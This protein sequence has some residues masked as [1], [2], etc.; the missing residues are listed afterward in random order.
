[1]FESMENVEEAARSDK[2]FSKGRYVLARKC[3]GVA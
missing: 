2:S 3:N 1:M